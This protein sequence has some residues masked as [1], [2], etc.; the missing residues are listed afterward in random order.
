M[1]I[2]DAAMVVMLLG[3][4]AWG[5]WRGMSW[6]VASIASLILGYSIGV[7]LS[8]Q[9]APKFPGEPLVARALALLVCYVAVSGGVFFV[10]WL[11]RATLRRIKFEAFDRHLGMIL[12]GVE[13]ILLG[14]I[15]TLFVVSLA[16]ASREP[17]FTSTSGKVVAKILATVEPILP[18][19]TGA[20]LK[21]FWEDRAQVVADDAQPFSLPKSVKVDIPLDG[22]SL[23]EAGTKLGRALVDEAEKS[24]ERVG[25][26]DDRNSP[27]R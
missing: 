6:Q 10:A 22:E 27:R 17:I 24:I 12:G 21:P 4:M 3:G 20:V 2:Y 25:R 14:I 9:L 18:A 7:P 11:I 8:A 13:G 26:T 19:E 23:Q 1:T 15:G 16:P 5:A